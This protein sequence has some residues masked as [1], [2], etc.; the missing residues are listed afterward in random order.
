MVV[1]L[2]VGIAH[3]S[4][5]SSEALGKPVLA[6]GYSGNLEF[7]REGNSL[8]VD[9]R[10]VPVAPGEYTVDDPRFVWAEPDIEAAARHMRTLADDAATRSRLAVAGAL[11]IRTNFTRERTAMLLRSRLVELGILDERGLT[12]DRHVPEH[13]AQ[14]TDAE[15]IIS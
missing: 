1:R 5:R 11:E 6:T 10:L 15:T 12:P 3:S 14:A 7:M 2:G 9:Y 4:E 8:L 13:G